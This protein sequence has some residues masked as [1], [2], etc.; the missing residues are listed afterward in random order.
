MAVSSTSSAK[1]AS[2]KGQVDKKK[3]DDINIG[4]LRMLHKDAT[5]ELEE[6]ILEVATT[7]LQSFYRGEKELYTEIAQEIKTKMDESENGSWHVIVGKSFGSFVTAE[8]KQ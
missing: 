6:R 8:V 5:K 4:T 1:A 2:V 3:K 7:A